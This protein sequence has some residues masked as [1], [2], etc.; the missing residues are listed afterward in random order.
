MRPQAGSSKGPKQEC[1]HC[2]KNHYGECR[3]GTDSCFKCGKSGHF[4]IDCPQ[5]VSGSG[6]GVGQTG[7]RQ[8]N[9]GRGHRGSMKRP[10]YIY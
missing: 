6:S 1:G 9:A 2:G 5:I 4:A 7:Q 10:Y 3:L 8:F